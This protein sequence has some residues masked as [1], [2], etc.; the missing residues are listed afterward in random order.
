M[1]NS[2]NILPDRLIKKPGS[3]ASL[4]FYCGMEWVAYLP[5]TVAP[6][7]TVVRVSHQD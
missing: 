4:A 5:G 3:F 2:R 6:E 7:T 1:K